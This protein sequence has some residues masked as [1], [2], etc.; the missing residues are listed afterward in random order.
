MFAMAW[1]LGVA[2][3]TAMLMALVIAA[4]AVSIRRGTGGLVVAHRTGVLSMPSR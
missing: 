3:D 4:I 1:F 2:L